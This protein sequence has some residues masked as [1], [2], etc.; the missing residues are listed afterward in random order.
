M[1]KWRSLRE[2]RDEEAAI[3][4]EI[5]ENELRLDSATHIEDFDT[6]EEIQKEIDK[7]MQ[8]VQSITR[9]MLTLDKQRAELEQR[10]SQ[11]KTNE[12]K[13]YSYSPTNTST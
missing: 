9:L 2:K 12:G 4:Q 1:Q 7:D 10:L 8:K 6:A 13:Y 11:I 3:Q 5:T